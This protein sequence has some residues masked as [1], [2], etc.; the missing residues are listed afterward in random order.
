MTANDIATSQP[1]K[2]RV[3][4]FVGL[5]CI[6]LI[7]C[8]VACIGGYLVFVRGV[9]GEPASADTIERAT[10]KFITA[11]HSNQLTA[12]HEMFSSKVRD[13]ISMNDVQKLAEEL[14][15]QTFDSLRVCEFQV[16]WGSYGKQ[17]TGYGLLQFSDGE[18]L[19][20]SSVLQDSD[21][22]WQISGFY[23]RP[24]LTKTPSNAC[25]IGQ[26]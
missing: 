26:P 4:L 14:P 16:L 22:K 17:L 15:I 10:L 2:S 23:F 11:L 20:E 25:A 24:D 13:N 1:K 7:I 5:G 19:F 6:V 21:G 12:A 3:P 18:V 9:N 8:L